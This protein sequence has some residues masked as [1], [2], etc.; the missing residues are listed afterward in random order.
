ML[1]LSFDCI[2]EWFYNF[3]GVLVSNINNMLTSNGISYISVQS[4]QNDE[5]WFRL[6]TTTLYFY[7]VFPNKDSLA[8]IGI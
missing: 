8:V 5:G 4:K 2:K 6:E 7:N 3:T 1:S